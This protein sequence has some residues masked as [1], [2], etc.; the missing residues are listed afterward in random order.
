M[1]AAL[2]DACCAIQPAEQL[3][4]HAPVCVLYCMRVCAW[5]PFFVCVHMDSLYL[6]GFDLCC[7][8]H[9]KSFV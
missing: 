5:H 8:M 1:C 3:C 4:V 7:C 9:M 2:H 6:L